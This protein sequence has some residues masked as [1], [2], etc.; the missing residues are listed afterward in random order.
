MK[1]IKEMVIVSHHTGNSNVRAVL[2]AFYQDDSL[3]S[4]VTTVGLADDEYALRK[5]SELI[6]RQAMRRSYS[7]PSPKI[8][9]RPYREVVRL[10]GKGKV[11]ANK[12]TDLASQSSISRDLDFF[13]S[14]FLV[15]S[16]KNAKYKIEAVYCYEK[17]AV[18]TFRQAQ[19]LGI[20]RIYDLPTG[21]WRTALRIFQE[22]REENA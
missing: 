22:E 3:A 13:T 15:K 17:T 5:I 10:L 2:D 20:F 6:Y 21:Y 19:K 8:V 12:E 4:F 11:F 9:R 16:F 7:I 1:W 14:R 18:E